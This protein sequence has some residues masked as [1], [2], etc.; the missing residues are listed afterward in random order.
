MTTAAIPLAARAA[1]EPPLAVTSV[2]GVTWDDEKQINVQLDGTPWHTTPQAASC[3]DTNQDG[4][5]DDVD[6]PYFAPAT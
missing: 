3:T 4:K 2:Q 6:D 1:A 5:G